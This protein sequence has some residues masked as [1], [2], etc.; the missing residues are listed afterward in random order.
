MANKKIS[1]LAPISALQI[2]AT[3]DVLPIVDISAN[4]TKKCTVADL[5]TAMLS[6]VYDISLYMPGHPGAG[7]LLAAIMLPR[8]V[9]FPVSFAQS[10]ARS[11]QPAAAPTVLTIKSDGVQIGQVTFMT[12]STQ[13]VFGGSAVTLNAGNRLEVYGPATLDLNLRDISLTFKGTRA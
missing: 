3:A 13:G 1:E 11:D 5:R 8:T 10:Q 12:G 4:S 7:K 9:W 2:D 6:D